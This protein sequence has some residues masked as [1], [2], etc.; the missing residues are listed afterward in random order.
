[1]TASELMEELK[2]HIPNAPIV[3]V[4]G[5]IVIVVTAVLKSESDSAVRLVGQRAPLCPAGDPSSVFTEAFAQGVPH[6]QFITEC[7]T[8]GNRP[9]R[10][11][12]RAAAATDS[13]QLATLH[14][15]VAFAPEFRRMTH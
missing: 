5:N 13:R 14:G 11:N 15:G 12:S 8:D 2:S 9:I 3:L 10:N 6:A 1:M 7:T 4:D